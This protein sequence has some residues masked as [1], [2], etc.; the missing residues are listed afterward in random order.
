MKKIYLPFVMLFVLNSYSQEDEPPTKQF[1][2]SGSADVYARFNLNSFNRNYEELEAP[3]PAT[4]FANDPGFA[5]GMANVVM[6]YEMGKIG[7]VADLVFG[8]RGEDAVFNSLGS[9]NIVNQLYV[10]WNASEKVTL[11]LG[12]WNT[13]LGYEVISPS[14]NFN[15]S[16]SYMFSYGPFSHTGI[17][18]DFALNDEFSAMV[19]V[20]NP[21]DFTE[22][23]PAG[24][25]TF[26]AQLGYAKE[27]GSVYLNFLYGDQDGKLEANGNKGGDISAGSTFQVDLATG[28]DLS[29]GFYLGF[30]TTYNTTATGE[31]FTDTGIR[32]VEGDDYGFYGAALY[33]QYS[34]N[35]KV[36][37]GARGEYFKEFNGGAGALGVY[38]AN[39]DS[40]V[41]AV[42]VSG[43]MAIGD[44]MLIPE[45]RMDSANQD[46]FINQD[47]DGTQGSLASI[48]LAAVYKF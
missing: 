47:I 32:D 46:I 31:A 3:A 34:L 33:L 12:N 44:L 8:P 16:T 45:V 40:S 10:Y 13:Y 43:N 23:N 41:F 6:N 9:S 4:S 7:A 15:Y 22:F 24:T 14:A 30:N 17:K 27:A 20:M 37:L 38:D 11:T 48:L 36:A 42:T 25:Y 19:A 35:D 28:V 1:N 5:I 18:A 39:G 2:I 21:T 29:D 26:G